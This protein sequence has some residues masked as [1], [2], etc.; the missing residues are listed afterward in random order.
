[1]KFDSLL[2]KAEFFEKLAVY[3]DRKAFL[4]ALAQQ[5]E[6]WSD[7]ARQLGDLPDDP[8]HTI[9]PPP[10]AKPEENVIV[11]PEDHIIGHR[12]LDPKTVKLWQQFLNKAL[13]PTGQWIPVQETGVMDQDTVKAARKWAEVN[14]VPAHDLASILKVL[15]N[16]AVA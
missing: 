14:K 7:V 3:G 1:M 13:V 16:K 9:P 11:M 15:K 10:P 8:P 5:G 6:T 2:K 12:P 4:Q